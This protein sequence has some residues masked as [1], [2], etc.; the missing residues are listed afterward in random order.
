LKI[1][2]LLGQ[3]VKLLLEK[4]QAPGVYSLKW[5]G[6]NNLGL[7]VPSGVYFLS[8]EVKNDKGVVF[9]QIKKMTL[10]R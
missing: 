5:N 9:S 3:E 7:S 2:N 1:Y 6:M 10:L 8:I 4:K